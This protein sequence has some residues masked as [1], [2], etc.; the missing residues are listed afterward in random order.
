MSQERFDELTRALATER[1]SRGRMLKMAAAATLGS[2]LGVGGILGSAE[3]AAAACRPGGTRCTK[4]KQCCSGTCAQNGTCC[5]ICDASAC[6][7]CDETDG[8]CFDICAD[9]TECLR[10]NNSGSC[11]PRCGDPCFPCNSVTKDCERRRC[12][13]PCHACVS[14]TGGTCE[15]YCSSP[16]EICQEDGITCLD[17]PGGTVC[18]ETCCG[19]CLTCEDPSTGKCRDCNACETCDAGSCVPI[20]DSAAKLCGEACCGSCQTCEDS[21][22]STCR[23]CDPNPR[24]C[25]ICNEGFCVTK[26]CPGQLVLDHSTCRCECPTG[27]DMCGTQCCDGSPPNCEICNFG[28]GTCVSL[29]SDFPS[30][31]EC[32]RMSSGGLT[33]C[34][35]CRKCGDMCCVGGGEDFCC[36]GRCSQSSTCPDGSAATL[37]SC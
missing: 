30:G 1:V 3:D 13:E 14:S 16:C 26:P 31:W 20:P 25:E 8:T 9:S 12:P 28:N 10:C 7:Q 15:D 22:T 6:Q 32:G 24:R 5:P 34:L 11:I 18:G 4:G 17:I 19:S 29:C 2:F 21:S 36:S 35:E 23:N 37:L 33:C 27:W